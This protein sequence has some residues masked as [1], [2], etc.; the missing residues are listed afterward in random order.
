MVVLWRLVGDPLPYWYRYPKLTIGSSDNVLSISHIEMDAA[1][2]M[3]TFNGIDH[4]V[5]SLSGAQL[6]DVGPPQTQISGT[7]QTM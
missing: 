1:G 4:S 6:V 2:V 3:C 5:T 7:C